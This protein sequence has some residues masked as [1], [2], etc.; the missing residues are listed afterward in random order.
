MNEDMEEVISV[1]IPVYNTSNYLERCVKSVVNQTYSALEIL[2]IDDGST[3]G[4]GV[5][6]DK[7]AELD[8]RVVAYHKENGGLSDARNYGIS[9][10]SGEIYAFI[11]SDDVI[12]ERFME[13][14]YKTM[15]QNASDIAA[16]GVYEF[17]DDLDIKERA[18]DEY[19]S[20][21]YK[22]PL[23]LQEY[24]HPH[25]KRVINHGLCMKIYRKALFEGLSFATGRLHEDLYITYK[26]LDRAKALVFVDEPLY[27]YFKANSNSICS[28]YGI[29]NYCDETDAAEEIWQYFNNKNE[30]NDNV[31]WFLINQNIGTLKRGSIIKKTTEYIKITEKLKRWIKKDI[32]SC[33]SLDIR[34]RIEAFLICTKTGHMLYRIRAK[35]LN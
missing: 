4:S 33:K 10:A 8:N 24:F 13:I 2:L 9:K 12:H 5:L 22:A 27:Y 25:G 3:D 6:C 21:V 19:T 30:L 17:C 16:C 15:V 31:I 11:D 32:G 7:M 34:K 35:V 29:K 14:L 1:I 18:V 26:L 28:N 20:W 23:L